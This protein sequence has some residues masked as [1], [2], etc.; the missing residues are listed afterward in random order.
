M[1]ESEVRASHA[2]ATRRRLV[3]P[4]S[5]ILGTFAAAAVTIFIIASEGY[6]AVLRSDGQHF[7]RVALDPFGAGRIFAGS[8]P[9]A[10]TAYRYGRILFP[11]A[12]WIVALGHRSA[13]TFALPAVYI[14]SILLFATLAAARCERAG[15]PP[16]AGLAALLVPD[17]NPTEPPSV[18]QSLVS[19]PWR[20]GPTQAGRPS[21]R[22]SWAGSPSSL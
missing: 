3:T 2:V 5:L 13:V 10:G 14:G 1:P 12:A 11:L 19:S 7:Y 16:V 18:S 4:E 8:E 22:H 9:G 21:P 20:G 6:G 15:R 17:V